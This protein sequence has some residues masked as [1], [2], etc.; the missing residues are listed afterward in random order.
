MAK[1]L[2][3]SGQRFGRLVAIEH[4]RRKPSPAVF[5]KCRCDCGTETV[6]RSQDLRD[7]HTRSCGCKRGEAGVLG[8]KSRLGEYAIYRGMLKR[9]YNKAVNGFKNYGGRGISVDGRW[10]EGEGALT[11]FECFLFD[12][13][14]RPSPKHSLERL[15]VNGDYARDNVVWGT[16]IQQCNNLRKTRWV[17]YRGARMP[18]ALA[19]RAA[20]SVIH[21]EAAWIRIG[22]GWAVERAL[23]TPR[24]FVSHAS[25]EYAGVRA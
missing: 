1:M 16:K 7:G 17:V 4:L 24:L 10:R 19:V 25:K 5:W 9:C 3:I 6:A 15:D 20:G 8:G 14:P 11:G 13:G 2:D 12:V 21:I 22:S 23:E 18:L